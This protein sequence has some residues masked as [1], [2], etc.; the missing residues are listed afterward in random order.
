[1][2]G[3]L[4]AKVKDGC[5]GLFKDRKSTRLNSRHLVISYAVFCLK[6]EPSAHVRRSR[7]AERIRAA[8]GQRGN[9]VQRPNTLHVAVAVFAQS[10]WMWPD[11]W[12]FFLNQRATPEIYTLSQPGP[13]PT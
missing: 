6:K 10:L 2:F 11:I 5:C 8:G 12:V 13:L 9:A 3:L 4:K 1:M 7:S